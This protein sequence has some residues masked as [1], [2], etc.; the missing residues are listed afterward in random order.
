MAWDLIWDLLAWLPWTGGDDPEV[1][2]ESPLVGRVVPVLGGAA[3]RPGQAVGELLS[4][5]LFGEAW[6][7]RCL[8]PGAS[9]VPGQSVRI[10]GVEG[11]LLYVEPV[12]EGSETVQALPA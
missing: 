9:P 10:V 7:A 2:R 12:G 4:V 5:E 11:T 1:K 8:K 3:V 6:Q